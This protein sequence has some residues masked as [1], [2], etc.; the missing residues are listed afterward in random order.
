[1]IGCSVFVALAAIPLSCQVANPGASGPPT[2]AAKTGPTSVECLYRLTCKLDSTAPYPQVEYMRLRL[3][4]NCSRFE[5]V[6]KVAADSADAVY[7]ALPFT[8]ENAQQMVDQLVKRPNP[9][10]SY[11][12]Y[13]NHLTNQ[14]TYADAIANKKYRYDEQ[15][16]AVRW[17]TAPETQSVAGYRCQRATTSFRG[18]DYVA[19]FT[20]QIPVSDGPYKFSGLPGLI[21]ALQD[22][23]GHYRFDMV[24]LRERAAPPV[25]A[26]PVAGVI[27]TTREAFNQGLADYNTNL[28]DRAMALGIAVPDPDAARKRVREK[29]RRRNNPLELK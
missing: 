25:E 1:M 21:V 13:K 6:R 8:P 11:T 22:T 19:W 16:D 15:P 18:R 7:D 20:R 17:R 10:F 12:I 29:Q 26:V 24:Q 4:A 9:L 14:V 5:S 27:R 28:V 3:T 2:A 23:R